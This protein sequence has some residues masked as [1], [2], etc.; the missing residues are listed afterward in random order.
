MDTIFSS[1]YQLNE[2]NSS[3]TVFTSKERKRKNSTFHWSNHI[4]KKK[5]KIY[6]NFYFN[7]VIYFRFRAPMPGLYIIS[8][9]RRISLKTEK[10]NQEISLPFHHAQCSRFIVLESCWYCEPYRAL[11]CSVQGVFSQECDEHIW[12]LLKFSLFFFE[13]GDNIYIVS[14]LYTIG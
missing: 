5:I 9:G 3:I 1:F 10:K 8:N 13:C 7:K 12:F 2:W 14:V 6:P 11:L 4:I